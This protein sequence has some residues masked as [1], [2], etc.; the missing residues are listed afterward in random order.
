MLSAS[1]ISFRGACM[2]PVCMQNCCLKAEQCVA[3]WRADPRGE[4]AD[5]DSHNC[6]AVTALACAAPP[7][8]VASS[9][10]TDSTA[11]LYGGRGGEAPAL[12]PS[13]VLAG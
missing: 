10:F 1:V 7:P 8:A 12:G 13:V 3:Q 9:S 4:M 5:G 11:S 6:N 2:Y